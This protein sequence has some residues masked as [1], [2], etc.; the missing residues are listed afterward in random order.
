VGA[1]IASEAVERYLG[2][3]HEALTSRDRLAIDH[4]AS[5]LDD[6]RITPYMRLVRSLPPVE[7]KAC[8]LTGRLIDLLDYYTAKAKI[9]D[10]AGT[11]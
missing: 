3:L 1:S 2:S 8:Y 5:R 4:A 7:R 11:R 6:R 10:R 9:D